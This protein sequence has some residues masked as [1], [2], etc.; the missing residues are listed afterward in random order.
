MDVESVLC[1]TQIGFCH[2]RHC[3]SRRQGILEVTIPPHGEQ[4]RLQLVHQAS[5]PDH[6]SPRERQDSQQIMEMDA[7]QRSWSR[8]VRARLSPENWETWLR[9]LALE[10]SR[11]G[12]DAPRLIRAAV[13]RLEA[14]PTG[15]MVDTSGALRSAGRLIAGA[16]VVGSLVISAAI[17]FS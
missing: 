16:I 2:R 17:V 1:G 8:V 7:M 15:H 6:D 4:W 3:R 14:E 10:I 9:A 5:H 11:I 12:D 13:R